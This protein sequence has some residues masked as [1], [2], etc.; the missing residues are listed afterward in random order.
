MGIQVGLL[1]KM[2]VTFSMT[3]LLNSCLSLNHSKMEPESRTRRSPMGEVRLINITPTGSDPRIGIT[4]YGSLYAPLGVTRDRFADWEGKYGMDSMGIGDDGS[5][6]IPRYPVFSKVAWTFIDY[7]DLSPSE[8]ED[9]IAECN[10]AISGTQNPSA[11]ELFRQI[12]DLALRAVKTSMTV[13][14]GPP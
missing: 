9:L 10:S 11:R 1:S 13:R 8:T 14:F 6:L 2:L 12:R 7:V 3:A 5:L 4:T